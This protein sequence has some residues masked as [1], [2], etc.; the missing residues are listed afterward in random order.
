MKRRSPHR[1]IYLGQRTGESPPWY[2]S[3]TDAAR[4][5]AQLPFHRRLRVRTSPHAAPVILPVVKHGQEGG[6]LLVPISVEKNKQGIVLGPVIA[7]L[8]VKKPG[9]A[10]FRGN[11]PNFRDIIRTGQRLGLTVAVMTP[12]S[13]RDDRLDAYVLT[14]SGRGTWRRMVLP[15]PSVVY[16]RVP[17]REAER[18]PGVVATKRWLKQRGIPIFNEG[19]FNKQDLHTWLTADPQAARYLPATEVLSSPEQ[20]LRMLQRYP[21]L[22]VKPVEGKAGDGIIQIRT[23]PNQVRVTQQRNGKR[24]R[25]SF[26][27]RRDAAQ[28][29]WRIARDGRYL[30]Q[31]GI[32]LAAYGGHRFDLRL[33]VQKNRNGHWRLTGM[34][35]RVADADGITTHVPNGGRIEK[36]AKA[37][38][39]TF[40][41]G[42]AGVERRV[43]EMA[44]QVAEALDRKWREQGHRLGELSMDV[45]VDAQGGLWFFEANAKP[46]K[47]DEPVIRAKSLLRLLHYCAFLARQG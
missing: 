38:R 44:L 30:L 14:G 37:L 8:T 19:F 26:R 33:L 21:L 40:G 7:I 36:A 46:M 9:T 6:D 29:V 28:A 45:G 47:F 22:Y 31:Q 32:H 23:T 42:S 13:V 10:T 39:A 4:L 3:I 18:D 34:G 1:V 15:L 5:H 16:N 2:L 35:A 43:R 25:R 24:T 27:T 17:D 41:A 12:E 11:K 20:L